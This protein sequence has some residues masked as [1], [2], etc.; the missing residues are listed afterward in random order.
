MLADGNWR[1]KYTSDDG[2]LVRLFY[3]PALG[4]AKSYDRL[5]GYFNAGALALAARG[6]EGLVRNGGHMRLVVG[7][8]LPPDEIEAIEEGAKLRDRVERHLTELPLAPPDASAGDALELLAWMVEH[9]CLDV[10]VAV[11]CD[12]ERRPIPADGIFHE[13]AGIVTDRGAIG[14]PGTAASTRPRRAGGTTG[15]ASTSTRAGVRN[16]GG[17]PTRRPTSRVSGQT[18]QTA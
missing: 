14:S 9:G 8:T 10:K 6:I 5:T 2:D 18:R 12:A 15:R 11:P 13:K 16:R 7:C 1:R 4:D 3:V 17:W